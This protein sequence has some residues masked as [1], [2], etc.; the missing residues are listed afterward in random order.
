MPNPR[1]DPPKLHL[2]EHLSDAIAVPLR[3][4]G[5]DVTTTL[6]LDMLE[7]PDPE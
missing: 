2:N 4:Q 1:R 5:F 6:E 7:A 3:K